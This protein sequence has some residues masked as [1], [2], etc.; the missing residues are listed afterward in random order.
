M[1]TQSEQKFIE[2]LDRETETAGKLIEQLRE[3]IKKLENKLYRS[4]P[5]I[6]IPTKE[7][8]PGNKLNYLVYS[9]A[10]ATAG[11]MEILFYTPDLDDLRKWGLDLK[12]NLAT[13]WAYLPQGP[14]ME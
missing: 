5:V 14:E 12:W 8:M 10:F 1:K 6:W 3:E 13:H 11:K 4:C 7:R 2:S 9:L